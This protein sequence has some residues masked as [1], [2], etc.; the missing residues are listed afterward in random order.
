MSEIIKT[1]ACSGCHACYSVC[2]RQC[3]TMCGDE[4]SFLYPKIDK[5]NCINCGKCTAVCMDIENERGKIGKGYA[6][7]NRDKE[8]RRQSS[9]GGVFGLLAEYI[10][11]RGG[12]VFGAA[13]D[14][15]FD[16]H[17]IYIEDA[18]DLYKLRGSKYVQ[19]TIG[20]TYREAKQ[21]LEAGRQ[22]LFS[23]TPCQIA[24]LVSF[25]GKTYENLILQDIICH[26][27]PSPKVWDM[28][29]QYQEA[30]AES[31][32]TGVGFREKETGWKTY[33]VK[34]SFE[35][36]KTYVEK[37]HNNSYMKAF[38]QNLALRPSCYQCRTK[39]LERQSDITLADFWGI[40]KLLPEMD[41]DKGASLVFVNSEKG[42]KL[43]SLIREK[44]QVQPVDIQTAVSYNTAAYQS[45]EMPKKRA[46]FLKNVSAETFR[47]LVEKYTK[48]SFSTRLVGKLKRIIKGVLRYVQR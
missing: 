47:E 9:S 35:N 22:V 28:Y 5:D 19:S 14:E 45:V 36:G 27:V 18:A 8:M 30:K 17:H 25:L 34:F 3:I 13:F 16:V 2:P 33:S 37:F 1:K 46:A 7:I 15:N 26:G 42:E 39:K 32:I 31:K 4:E 11:T 24:G 48:P 38:L 44:M 41:D 29:K 40:E 20:E 43:F 6:C 21:F 12:V 10:L 23:G